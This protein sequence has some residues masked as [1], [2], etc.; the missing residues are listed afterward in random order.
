MTRIT[1]GRTDLAVAA[2]IS[3]KSMISPGPLFVGD[4]TGLP[5][6]LDL[7]TINAGSN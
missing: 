6:Q 1:H 3:P 5:G 2:G 7:V 4:F